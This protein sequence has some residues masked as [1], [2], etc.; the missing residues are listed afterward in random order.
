MPRTFAA[1]A[2]SLVLM[3]TGFATAFARGQA[4]DETGQV[5]VLCSGGGLVQITLDSQ[6]RPTG[7]SHLCPDLASNLLAALSAAPPETTPLQLW[8]RLNLIDPARH[9]EGRVLPGN[10][11]RDPPRFVLN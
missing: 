7:Q 5:V 2:L 4:F 9:G 11:A 8:Q 3:L 1:F 6:G 10:T